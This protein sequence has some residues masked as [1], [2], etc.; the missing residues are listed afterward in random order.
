[1]IYEKTI[2][3]KFYETKEDF[4]WAQKERL[5]EDNSYFWDF[6]E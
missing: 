2:Q 5:W 4:N 6:D 1:M 3:I